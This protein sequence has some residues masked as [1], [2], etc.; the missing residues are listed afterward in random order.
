MDDYIEGRIAEVEAR[1]YFG[2]MPAHNKAIQLEAE[3][4]F[5]AACPRNNK[6]PRHGNVWG[7][8]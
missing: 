8:G 3:D 7:G 2:S 6:N 4:L 5:Y 1:D